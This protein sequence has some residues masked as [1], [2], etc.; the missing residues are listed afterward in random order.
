MSKYK[1]FLTLIVGLIFSSPATAYSPPG[2]NDTLSGV[3]ELKPVFSFEQL[4]KA[5]KTAAV[6]FLGYGD[7]DPNAG[8]GSGDE[9]Y[10][11]DTAKQCQNEGFS[12]VNCNSVQVIDGTCPYNSSYGKGCKCASNLVTC[13][14]GQVGVGES[15]GGKYASCQCDPKL[16]SCASNQVGQ[17]ASC[18]GK[19]QS[20]ACKSEYVYNSSNC[21]SPRSLSGAS[22]GG[23]YTGC[24][25]PSGVSAGTYGC[26]EYYGS[27]CS[28]VCKKAYTDNCHKRT[29]N[30]SALYGCMK[31]WSDCPSKCETP[32]KDNCRN[33]TAVSCANGCASYFD[34]CSSKCST[35]KEDPCS[36]RTAVS[37]PQGCGATYSDCTSKCQ[38]CKVISCNT[39]KSAVDTIL[40]AGTS[41]TIGG[42]G[43]YNY[44]SPNSGCKSAYRAST[45]LETM[46][47]LGWNCSSCTAQAADGTQTSGYNCTC[48]AQ[49]YYPNGAQQTGGRGGIDT[50]CGGWKIVC[51]AMKCKTGYTYSGG[52]CVAESCSGYTLTSCP[53]NGT[54]SSCQAGSTKK[55]KLTSCKSG[56]TMSGNTCVAEC[57]YEDECSG[58]TATSCTNGIKDSC[59]ACGVTKYK[60][61]LTIKPIEPGGW[62]CVSPSHTVTCN[63]MRCCCPSGVG[64]EGATS[65]TGPGNVITPIKCFCEHTAVSAAQ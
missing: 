12:K 8:F 62:N 54:C 27:P 25:C 32:Y 49:S 56:Y 41:V 5:F 47:K 33:R 22:C 58:F 48:A 59:T 53:A 9:N 44:A 46:K 65:Q 6:C 61:N 35:C 60:C 19:Y 4:D 52:G 28:S 15:C 64:C 2:N 34:D 50:L 43:I 24:S 26:A 51:P 45:A 36:S 55:Y 40:T 18:G 23:K 29:D 11:I 37:C 20:C 63:G 1:L 17:G 14:A 30:N 31:Y 42:Q 38:S 39:T 13:P 21:K 3:S 57:K 16:V 7:C 10:S